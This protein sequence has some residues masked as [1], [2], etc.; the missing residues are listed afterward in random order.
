MKT[1]NI[2][3][4][5]RAIGIASFPGSPGVGRKESLGT[6]LQ[7]ASSEAFLCVTYGIRHFG[8]RHSGNHPVSQRRLTKT[9]TWLTVMTGVS[10]SFSV[11]VSF[12][13]I[14]A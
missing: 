11:R 2:A 13:A 4:T 12:R 3:D 9:Q 7:L 8:I 5:A 6:R 1:L 14:F 10:P